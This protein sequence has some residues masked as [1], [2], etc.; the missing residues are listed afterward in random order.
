MTSTIGVTGA[1]GTVGSAVIQ[2]L[3]AHAV[4]VRTL[5]RATPAPTPA[6]SSWA[7]RSAC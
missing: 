3:R 2:Q 4:H 7:W 6:A 5:P 1:T